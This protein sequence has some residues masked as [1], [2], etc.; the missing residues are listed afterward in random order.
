MFKR[1]RFNPKPVPHLLALQFELSLSY[2][3][4]VYNY[5]PLK[6]LIALKLVF[7][8]LLRLRVLCSVRPM[9]LPFAPR[10]LPPFRFV[11]A[12]PS[13]SDP[14]PFETLNGLCR[15]LQLAGV[16]FLGHCARVQVL[17]SAEVSRNVSYQRERSAVGLSKEVYPVDLG[18]YYAAEK[19]V[20]E[21]RRRSDLPSRA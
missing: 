17:T 21:F 10:P 7:D 19:A 3:L 4:T 16:S 18:Y 12:P 13:E 20:C 11:V 6:I 1:V 14:L 9:M 8:P 5:L 15:A 2:R